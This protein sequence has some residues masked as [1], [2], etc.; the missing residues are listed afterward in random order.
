MLTFGQMEF[1]IAVNAQ[2]SAEYKDSIKL[3]EH[4]LA[5][6]GASISIAVAADGYL[7]KC[8]GPYTFKELGTPE[9]TLESNKNIT[10]MV[11]ADDVITAMSHTITDNADISI[12]YYLSDQN[13]S[14]MPEGLW[15][16]WNGTT[17]PP[18]DSNKY[19]YVRTYAKAGSGYMTSAPR[20][21]T[22]SI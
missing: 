8:S 11:S 21:Y 14:E 9:V 12:Q 16:T 1:G 5:G 2:E 22:L 4:K 10:E 3:D 17:K 19:L 20:K 7:P 13:L 15:E 6:E 18:L